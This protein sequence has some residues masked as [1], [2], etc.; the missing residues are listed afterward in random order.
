LK[1]YIREK[2]KIRLPNEEIM[3]YAFDSTMNGEL[4]NKA[5]ALFT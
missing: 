3:Y 5:I 2:S 1:V 4:N